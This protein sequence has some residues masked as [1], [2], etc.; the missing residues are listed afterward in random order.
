[1]EIKIEYLK[2]EID[3]SRIVV[4]GEKV[5]CPLSKVLFEDPL[6]PIYTKLNFV[7]VCHLRLCVD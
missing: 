5:I 6:I 2:S 3:E 1:M 4:N 7:V